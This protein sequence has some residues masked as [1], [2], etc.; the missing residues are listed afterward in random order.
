MQWASSPK[1]A[2]RDG[3]IY[4]IYSD[5]ERPSGTD[6]TFCTSGRVR[7]DGELSDRKIKTLRQFQAGGYKPLSRSSLLIK[8]RQVRSQ[9]VNSIRRSPISSGDMNHSAVAPQIG[10]AS[11]EEEAGK[12][13]GGKREEKEE[14]TE[15]ELVF[16]FTPWPVLC[17]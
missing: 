5:E 12:R 14:I 7:K 17:P 3:V 15:S 13:C 2:L 1:F 6:W 16:I 4:S 8:H 11:I 10:L 9:R